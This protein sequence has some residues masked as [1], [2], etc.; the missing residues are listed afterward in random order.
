MTTPK[1]YPFD[2]LPVHPQPQPLESF[3]SYL[4]RL[5]EANRIR[6]VRHLFG[7]C[8]P[9]DQPGFTLNNGDYPPRSFGALPVIAACPEPTLR[10]TT[11]YYLAQKFGRRSDPQPLSLFISGVAS[12]GLRYCPDCLAERSYYMLTWRFLPLE[13][14]PEHGR[15]LLDH[16]QHCGQKIPLLTQPL[17]ILLCPVCGGD[18]RACQADRLNDAAWRTAQLWS[19]D[20]TFLLSPLAAEPPDTP[21]VKFIGQQFFR[22]RQVR[23]LKIPDAAAY[24][25]Q[26]PA[27]IYYIE[28]GAERRTTKLQWYFRYADFLKIR[29]EPM[30]DTP[31]PPPPELTFE[32]K[33]VDK[34]EQA[35]DSLRQKG[36]PTTRDMIAQVIGIASKRL[37]SYPRVSALCTAGQATSRHQAETLLIEQAWQ[38]ASQVLAETGQ[39]LSQ[40]DLYRRLGWSLSKFN[41]QPRVKTA[42]KQMFEQLQ[43]QYEDRLLHQLQ[44][45][46]DQL[47]A[48]GQ[49]VS[50]QALSLKVGVSLKRM[51]GLPRVNRFLKEQVLDKKAEFAIRTFQQRE[52]ALIL[53]IEQAIE[54]LTRSEQ[55]VTR[56]AIQQLL[57]RNPSSW[58]LYPRVQLLL[59]EV[60]LAKEQ[61]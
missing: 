11:F 50:K 26:S 41:T 3:T 37:R 9:K 30:F 61:R 60:T 4:T 51:A 29:F 48:T 43:E 15:L 5:A 8:F 12:P 38:T 7:L 19:Q 33:L 46:L 58:E 49:V 20:L 27:V 25:E 47:E 2:T 56:T 18:L 22:W 52:Q 40:R 13:G 21:V 42:L 35:L 16:C 14:C 53:E 55:P 28:K 44:A 54:T 17:R 32:D 10:A 39:L 36:L 34:V 59:K 1:V 45:A 57:K 24:L 23:R 31:L 6:T